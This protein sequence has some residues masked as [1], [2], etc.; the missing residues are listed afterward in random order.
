[1]SSVRTSLAVA[2]TLITAIVVL[3]VVIIAFSP[4]VTTAPEF[5]LTD[6]D[7][8]ELKLIDL[9]SHVVVLDFMYIACEGCKP[10][11]QNLKDLV[12]SYGNELV[13]ISVDIVPTDSEDMLRQYRDYES[14]IWHI[15][16][17]TDSLG[18]KYG[19]GSSVPAVVIIDGNGV[20]TWNW[21]AIGPFDPGSQKAEM[22]SAIL[23]AISGSAT[24][25]SVA[26]V[27]V[28]ALAILA[29]LGS[30]FSPCSF[31]LLP[32]YMAYYLGLDAQSKQRPSTLVAASRGF[33]ASIGMILVYGIIAIVVFAVGYSAAAS[34][35]YLGPIVGGIL[36]FLGALTLSNLQYH[37]F[38][39]PFRKLR[40][41][42]F[43]K[44]EG[45]EAKDIGIGAKMFG[46][47]VGYGAAGFACVAPPFIAAVLN[48]TIYGSI[49][50]G[51]LVLVIYSALV[52]AL[53]I[54]ITIL[55]T[56]AGQIAIQK[57]NK[58]VNVIK[59][60]S[61]IALII[62]GAYLIYYYFATR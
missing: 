25:M 43:P 41:K 61:G 13:V 24:P 6:V 50:Y 30:F 60:V 10:V 44:K 8:Q 3:L 51:I 39:E 37:K 38:V 26:Q 31:P 33:F 16:R 9:R 12:P 48:A 11:T 17:D 23:S 52:I 34:V 4:Q 19:V 27:S 29:A 46:Y 14:I 1:M 18:S 22:D 55:L 45:D 35:Q 2:G 53:M 54:A 7:G 21:K 5:T 57:M 62:A 20:V 36:V 28:P 58:Y 56:E 59:K 49:F 40:Q 32:G 42:I 47:G 15:A